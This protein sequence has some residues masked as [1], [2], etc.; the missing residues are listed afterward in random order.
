M[1][2]MI[3]SRTI[4]ISTRL[5]LGFGSVLVLLMMIVGIGTWRLQHIDSD[6]SD[7]VDNVMQKERLFSTWAADTR[8]NG[9]RALLAAESN[10]ATRKKRFEMQIKETSTEI[11]A[12]QKRLDA[13]DKNPE[14]TVM[15]SQIGER[16][17]IYMAAR[18]DVLNQNAGDLEQVFTLEQTRL[19]PALNDYVASIKRLSD[20]QAQL[21]AQSAEKTKSQTHTSVAL[22]PLLGVI[23]IIVGGVVTLMITRFIKNQLGGE[24]A[25]AVN[26]M[27]F[28]SEGDLTGSIDTQIGDRTS[29]LYA[30]KT[31]R[32]SIAD[33]VGE[34]LSGAE[35][36]A[37]VSKQIASGNMDLSARTEHQASALEQIASSME[38]FTSILKL[39]AESTR[40]ANRL[41][42][43]ATTFA[44]DGKTA[45]AQVVNTMN[46]ISESSEKIVDIIGVIDSIAFQTNIL[47]LNAAV[48]AAR[49]GEQGR[50][51]AVVAAEV[52][53]LAQRSAG[54]ARE[55]KTLIG[56][57][58]EKVNI[59]THLV[60]Q[61]DMTMDQIVASVTQAGKII[62]N[63][64]HASAEQTS[65]IE[66]ISIAVKQMDEVTQQNAALVEE[67][68]A[69]AQ[70]MQEQS[71]N[72]A[73][74]VSFFRL[75]HETEA[76]LAPAGLPPGPELQRSIVAQ[77][78]QTF[79][80]VAR[81]A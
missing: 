60:D 69:A 33:V 32:D 13:F 65:G 2:S 6:V 52:R 24:P 1:N 26:A 19:E 20:Y 25:A 50:G 42:A 38:Q 15:V 28:I 12:I 54:A 55:I 41:A 61:A 73:H 53:N 40:E 29:M 76:P 9:A 27:R 68:A 14:E 80:P 34:V 43:G 66:Q 71:G 67:A 21:I 23:A 63:I 30:V 78:S 74:M 70:S 72:L 5:F 17:K 45:M 47:A 10:N 36:I 77:R 51:F 59:G 35:T 56:D 7:M 57:S 79:L 58:V 48:E 8:I 44:F 75:T 11:S 31:M 16:R 49:A 22:L 39:N 37:V 3:K 46:S 18:D 64:A 4:R 62:G 81:A